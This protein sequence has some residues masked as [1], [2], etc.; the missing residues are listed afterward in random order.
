M[1]LPALL[2]L[3]LFLAGGLLRAAELPSPRLGDVAPNFTLSTLDDKAVELKALTAKSTVVL[4]VLRGWPGYQCPVC[5][6]QVRDF[7]AR[8]SDFAA[9]G[10]QV[11][12]VYPGPAA[13]LKTRA[14]EFLADKQWPANFI[15]LLDPDYVFTNA[16]ALRWEAKNETA[17]PSTFV[18]GTDGKIRFAQVSKTHGGRVGVAQ[19]LEQ[20]K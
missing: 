13:E 12:M 8:A 11:V 20:L 3:S 14:K 7:A 16:Y 1:K 5:T 9:R 6:R 18:I 15:F 17:F 2:S 19:A 10:A 4:V